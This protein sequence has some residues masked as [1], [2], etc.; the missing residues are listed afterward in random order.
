MANAWNIDLI[1]WISAVELP[2]LGGM[3]WFLWRTRRESDAALTAHQHHTDQ[4]VSQLRD[5]VAAYKLD[6]ARSYAS[7][8]CLKDVE[9]RLTL[10]LQRIEAKLDRQTAPPGERV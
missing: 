4:T 7:I 9:R 5:N 1:N 6:V 10:H 8:D 3:F 2:V